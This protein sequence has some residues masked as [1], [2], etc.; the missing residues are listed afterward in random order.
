VLETRKNRLLLLA[1]DKWNGFNYPATVT[2][3]TF[4]L[5]TSATVKDPDYPAKFGLSGSTY[6]LEG[7]TL[8]R[9]KRYTAESPTS[10]AGS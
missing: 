10:G 5:L 7:G 6:Q 3:R 9:I 2:S 4:V 1:G 8:L